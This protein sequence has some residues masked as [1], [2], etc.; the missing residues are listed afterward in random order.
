MKTKICILLLVGYCSLGY[1]QQVGDGKAVLISDFS[2]PLKTGVYVTTTLQ[3]GYPDNSQNKYLLTMRTDDLTANN[4][5]QIASNFGENDRVFFRKITAGKDLS[6]KNTPWYE[7]ATRGAN[8]FTGNQVF[9]GTL[10]A[11]VILTP[12]I[13]YNTNDNFSYDGKALSHYSLNWVLDSWYPTAPTLWQSAYGGMKFFTGGTPR[14]AIQNNGNIGIGTTNPTVKLD[15]IGIIRAQEVR[16]CLNQ[17]CDYVFNEDYKLMNL[18]DLSNFVKTNKHLPEIAPAAQME[19]EDIN[20]SEMNALLL[21]KVEELTLYT[22]QQEERIKAL[23][24]K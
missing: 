12:K 24:A 19:K 15:V 7:F 13:T 6:G 4:Q 5:F 22:L 23:E 16:V 18:N 11:S 21:K 20:V 2:V 3:A 14:L 17:G 10:Q 9:N 8:T 1:S